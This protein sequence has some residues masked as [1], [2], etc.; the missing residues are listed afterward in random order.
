MTKCWIYDVASLRTSILLNFR[1]TGSV[2]IIPLRCVKALLIDNLQDLNFKLGFKTKVQLCDILK[3]K[4]FSDS[5]HLTFHVKKWPWKIEMNIWIFLPIC[6]IWC[7]WEKSSKI[8]KMFRLT[9][10]ASQ[11]VEWF[12][13]DRKTNFHHFTIIQ[14]SF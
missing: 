9:T 3:W 14:T 12:C 8:S 5:I 13:L 7:C 6:L 1:S 11:L 4:L 2:G 10:I